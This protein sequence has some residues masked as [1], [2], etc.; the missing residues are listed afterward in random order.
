MVMWK[1]SL[2]ATCHE[3]YITFNYIYSFMKADEIIGNIILVFRL[4]DWVNTGKV[5]CAVWGL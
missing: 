1:L 4:L 3:E 2:T 5:G